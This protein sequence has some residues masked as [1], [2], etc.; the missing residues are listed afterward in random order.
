GWHWAL[1]I[2]DLLQG[3]RLYCGGQSFGRIGDQKVAQAEQHIWR[4]LLPTAACNHGSNPFTTGVPAPDPNGV[5]ISGSPNWNTLSVPCRARRNASHCCTSL[6]GIGGMEMESSI[7]DA[8][9]F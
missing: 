6:F 9:Q 4:A 2:R 3:G 5:A 8:H 7:Q 1:R